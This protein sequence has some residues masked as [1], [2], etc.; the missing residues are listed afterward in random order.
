ML[1]RDGVYLRAYGDSGSELRAG[2]LEVEL[3]VQV[4]VED[5]EEVDEDDDEAERDVVLEGLHDTRGLASKTKRQQRKDTQAQ[6]LGKRL[7]SQLPTIRARR[8][9]RGLARRPW[10][11]GAS[12]SSSHP[13]AAS[14]TH[15]FSGPASAQQPSPTSAD[16]TSCFT[17]PACYTGPL[18]F[19]EAFQMT[20][21]QRQVCG[22]VRTIAASRIQQ[23]HPEKAC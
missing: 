12:S 22:H 6:W 15:M 11:Q 1:I 17:G 4:E 7:R 18:Y 14:P 16:V 13:G 8:S 21:A 19:H 3:D 23:T 10:R 5:A 9:V 2:L 20:H